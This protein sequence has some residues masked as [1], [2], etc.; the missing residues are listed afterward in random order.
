MTAIRTNAAAAMLGVSASTL[1]SWERRYGFPQPH[2]SPGGHRLY[3]LADVQAL[4]Q[5]LQEVHNISSAVA[6]ACERGTG[7][8]SAGRLAA[9]YAAFDEEAANRQLEE[10]LALRSVERTI[11]ELLLPG[12]MSHGVEGEG[13]TA[14]YE[15]AWRHATGWLAAIKRLAPPASLPEAVLILD[16]SGPCDADALHAQALE[17]VLRRAGLR[18]LSL[19]PAIEPARLARAARALRPGAVILSGR[20]AP[21]DT[22]G[23]LVYA[24]RS[25]G[26]GT[27]VF[28]FRGAVPDTGA[29]TVVRLGPTP[30]AARD[31][32]LAHLRAPG[33]A[34]SGHA[35]ATL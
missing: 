9:A 7:P 3:A 17:V 35:A 15:F 32:L 28:D 26:E 21:L 19:T 24:V 23:R 22:V 1:R 31:V 18:A 16:S 8:A 14:E 11:E 4:R 27:T 25:G 10:S 12:V 2:R 13:R 30:S 34:M 29:S 5:T 33:A 20:R 6:I